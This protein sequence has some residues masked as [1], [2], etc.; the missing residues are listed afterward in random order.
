MVIDLNIISSL[1]AGPNHLL[2]EEV[3][4][5][6]AESDAVIEWGVKLVNINILAMQFE[7][8]DITVAT[9]C[10]AHQVSGALLNVCLPAS[11]AISRGRTIYGSPS[12]QW[13]KCLQSAHA[14]SKQAKLKC[15]TSAKKRLARAVEWILGWVTLFDSNIIGKR[16][17]H[18]FLIWP[19]P[20]PGRKYER[21]QLDIQCV[22]TEDG[23][24]PNVNANARDMIPTTAEIWPMLDLAIIT[25]DK[26]TVGQL[27]TVLTTAGLDTIQ[28]GSNC[29]ACRCWVFRTLKVFMDACLIQDDWQWLA[30]QWN[31]DVVQVADEQ[32]AGVMEEDILSLGDWLL[33]DMT[34]IDFDFT[35]HKI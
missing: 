25:E 23:V 33:P 3:D 30:S 28:M 16:I 11:V 17:L 19:I 10:Y 14:G 22:I 12:L 24:F 9:P 21:I 2:E 35:P 20:M 13:W 5:M 34:T 15:M 29:A 27:M 8:G 1:G 31:D 26:P 18:Y 7:L 6:V 32:G 4:L